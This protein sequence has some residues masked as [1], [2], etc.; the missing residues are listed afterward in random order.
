MSVRAPEQELPEPLALDTTSDATATSEAPT[1]K[2]A[3][4]WPRRTERTPRE[5]FIE[6]I[7]Q[8]TDDQV[9]EWLVEIEE[10]LDD[11]DAIEA[12]HK[13]MEE[14]GTVPWEEVK[15]KLGLA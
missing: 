5:R 3:A 15:A 14:E 12:A 7:L 9:E 8:M 2:P 1:E 11:L 10:E 4:R 6:L 13:E